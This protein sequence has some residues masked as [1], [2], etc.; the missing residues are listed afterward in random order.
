MSEPAIVA[1]G[2]VKRFGAVEALGGVDLEIPAGAVLGLL[3]PN[4]A[5]KTTVVR[6]LTTLLRP[7]AGRARVAGLDVVRQAAAVR[8]RIGLSGQFA[9]VDPYLSGRENL[10]MIG[11]LSGLGRGRARH[12]AG[13][14]LDTFELTA[15]AERVVRGYSGGMR[16]RL[17]VAA[18]LV[19]RP[20]VL[21]LDEPTTGL[22]PRGR[23]GLW[24]TIAEL[25]A[26]GATVL[27]TTQYLEE[28]DQRADS[29]MVIDAGRVIATGTSD[30]LK[31]QVGG[32]RLELRAA[33]GVDPV[34]LAAAVADLGSGSPVVD[35]DECKVVL[36]VVDGQSVLGDAVARLGAA[37]LRVTDVALRRASLDDVFLALT[38]QSA[39]AVGPDLAETGSRR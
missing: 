17:D 23:I 1:E 26:Q 24:Q 31:A 32:D 37:D 3:G 12:R 33:P 39:T 9:A 36:P 2:L 13:E 28:A 30:E 35:A 15:A 5:G 29:I 20:S 19:A 6:I 10:Q 27:L 25:T 38:G 22:D 7:D 11:R 8:R 14:L 16:R 21:F 18:S 34:A 4:G